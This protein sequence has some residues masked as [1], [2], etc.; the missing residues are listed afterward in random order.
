MINSADFALSVVIILPLKIHFNLSAITGQEV[1]PGARGGPG[2]DL[3][4]SYAL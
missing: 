3:L 2:D 1:H 4:I